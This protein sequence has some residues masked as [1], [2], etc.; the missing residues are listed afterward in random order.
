VNENFTFFLFFVFLVVRNLFLLD[1]KMRFAV[2]CTLA[3]AALAGAN[4]QAA[5]WGSARANNTA[6]ALANAIARATEAAGSKIVASEAAIT[7]L[8]KGVN[9]TALTAAGVTV[10]LLSNFERGVSFFG[11]ERLGAWE[12]WAEVQARGCARVEG[13]TRTRIPR[14]RRDCFREEQKAGVEE[15]CSVADSSSESSFFR[16]V[17]ALIHVVIQLASGR[18]ASGSSQAANGLVISRWAEDWESR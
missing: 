9:T 1:K 18:A 13:E 4:A 16:L 3:L 5:D 7:N 8:E 17:G 12:N 11:A 15:G 6:Q 2:L 10:S 14:L